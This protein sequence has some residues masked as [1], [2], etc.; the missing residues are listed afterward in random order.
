PKFASVTALV[1]HYVQNPLDNQLRF[2]KPIA[3][4][5]W[6]L[7]HDSVEC[8]AQTGRLGAGRFTTYHGTLKLGDTSRPVVV[9]KGAI[10]LGPEGDLDEAV[11]TRKETML[12]VKELAYFA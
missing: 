6:R 1:E 10:A 2:S 4:P 7:K 12:E 5:N 8:C 9:K 3:R 11:E